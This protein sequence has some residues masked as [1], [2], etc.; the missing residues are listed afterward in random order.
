MAL[1]VKA[2]AHSMEGAE[3]EGEAKQM[4]LEQPASAE[5]GARM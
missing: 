5:L 4:L 1:A 3:A 2:E